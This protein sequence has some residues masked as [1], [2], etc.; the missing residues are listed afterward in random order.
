MYINVEELMLLSSQID[1]LQDIIEYQNNEQNHYFPESIFTAREN[2]NRAEDVI[3]KITDREVQSKAK[4]IIRN[5]A[6][7]NK[8]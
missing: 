5:R 6:L 1:K 3:K 2:A 8:R 4:K 7:A